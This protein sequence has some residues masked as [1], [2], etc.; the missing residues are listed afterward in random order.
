MYN[1][2]NNPC[3]YPSAIHIGRKCLIHAVHGVAILGRQRQEFELFSGPIREI[4]VTKS[5]KTHVDF[6][7]RLCSKHFVTGKQHQPFLGNG[8]ICGGFLCH[9]SITTL[10][11]SECNL[12]TWNT[13]TEPQH[14]LSRSGH[15][16]FYVRCH[17]ALMGSICQ[18]T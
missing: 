4:T 13:L 15:S 1:P 6:Y 11:Y 5:K 3:I 8:A 18:W 10:K 16:W 9:L 17:P 7:T 14:D 12:E 2:S